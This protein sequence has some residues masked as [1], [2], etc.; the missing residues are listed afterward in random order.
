MAVEANALEAVQVLLEFKADVN[1]VHGAR[2]TTAAH[3]AA[4]GGLA[5]ALRILL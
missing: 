5:M 2:G 3:V 4:G 1:A